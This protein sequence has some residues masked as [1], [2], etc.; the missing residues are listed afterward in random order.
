M[1]GDEVTI[2]QKISQLEDEVR[3]EAI[4][5]D[6]QRLKQERRLRIEMEKQREGK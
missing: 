4:R 6:R 5:Q 3:R 2:Q 1:A